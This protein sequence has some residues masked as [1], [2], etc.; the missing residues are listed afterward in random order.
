V[1]G[2][3]VGGTMLVTSRSAAEYRAMFDLSPSDLADA[4]ILDCCAGGSSF[5]AETQS[6]VVAADPAYASD[7]ATLAAAAHNGRVDGDRMIEDNA[8]RFEWEWY[9]TRARRVAMRAE[10]V[11]RFVADLA[12]RPSRYVAAALPRLP[13][14]DRSFDLVL[15]SHLLFTWA[16]TF[17]REWH[18]AALFELAR[19]AEREVRVFP[20][21]LQGTGAPVDFLTELCGDLDAAGFRTK[22]RTV[23]Y[24]FQRG[25]DQM[26][27]IMTSH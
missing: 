8:D 23:P 19:V 13:F 26:L 18:R 27:S 11:R 22:R 25:A 17:D 12:E 21:V 10:A 3:G 5:T 7:R 1:G 2:D 20:L 14:A 16:D 24:R 4:S 9:G 6:F 15:C